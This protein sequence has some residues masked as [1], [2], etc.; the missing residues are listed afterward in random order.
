MDARFGP[1]L[2]KS[3]FAAG[4]LVR[5][6]LVLPMA[7]SGP[8]RGSELLPLGLAVVFAMSVLLAIGVFIAARPAIALGILSAL[9]GLVLAA[10][11]VAAG[12]PMPWPVALGACNAVVGALALEA[13]RSLEPEA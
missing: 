11:G 1:L 9:G 7:P 3:A 5:P 10:V 6:V 12:M 2:W 8:L 4:L 13:W